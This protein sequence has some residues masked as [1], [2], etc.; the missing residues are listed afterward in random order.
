MDQLRIRSLA[1]INNMVDE[2]A[3]K[4][5]GVFLWVALVVK[6]L[7]D[8]FTNRDRISDLRRRLSILPASLHDLFTHM[9]TKHIDPIY[10]E[11]SSRILLIVRTWKES[12][13]EIPLQLLVLVHAE[14][15][16]G[17]LQIERFES[18]LRIKE[19]V[20]KCDEMADRLKSHCAGLLETTGT[21]SSHSHLSPVLADASKFLKVQFLHRSVYDFLLHTETENIL[22]SRVQNS[23][24]AHAVLFYAQLLHLNMEHIKPIDFLCGIHIALHS[25]REMDTLEIVTKLEEL[26]TAM[27]RLYHLEGCKIH[28]G[29]VLSNW[30]DKYYSLTRDGQH[31]SSTDE[32]D[33]LSFAIH[34]HLVPYLK[35]K[36]EQNF[37][38][39][40]M[41]GGRPYLDYALRHN[42]DPSAEIVQILLEA[43]ADPN[44]RFREESLWQHY[45]YLLD[46]NTWESEGPFHAFISSDRDKTTKQSAVKRRLT[47]AKLLLEAGA[48]P[49]AVCVVWHDNIIRMFTPRY[50]FSSQG[51]HH[52]AALAEVLGLQG[53][54][55]IQDK[56]SVKKRPALRKQVLRNR[57]N[58]IQRVE[59][60]TKSL[61]KTVI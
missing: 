9:L 54:V 41:K 25:L 13:D 16:G 3:D 55:M 39:L 21:L 46:R 49:N 28:H 56:V 51:T 33:L 45:L 40:E 18:F 7:L 58:F 8:G 29:R 38:L 24:N 20:L 23:F 27:V 22:L 31:V 43:G 26:D 2:I 11:E 1:D 34:N 17:A 50:V 19:C 59:D 47:I 12:F 61:S 6:S 10:Q 4:A 30:L 57:R 14:E 37:D 52:D 5:S 32:N 48:E 36:L 42:L 53:G 15:L 35:A 44:Q 60:A